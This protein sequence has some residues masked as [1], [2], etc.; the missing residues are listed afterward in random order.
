[1]RMENEVYMNDEVKIVAFVESLQQKYK[2]KFLQYRK[3]PL[4]KFIQ[5]MI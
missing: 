2:A 1:M 5:S 4:D 3:L